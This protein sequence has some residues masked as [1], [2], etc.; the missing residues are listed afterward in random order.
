MEG[1]GGVGG[2]IGGKQTKMQAGI[3]LPSKGTEDFALILQ[4]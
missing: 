4:K 3:V 1:C 2:Q